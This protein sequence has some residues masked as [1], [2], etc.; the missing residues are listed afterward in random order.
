MLNTFLYDPLVE[1]KKESRSK[2]GTGE[3]SND[4]VSSLVDL[5]QIT[6]MIAFLSLPNFR[7]FA[8]NFI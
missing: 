3:K 7:R 6:A 4:M 1:W 8:I 5:E 2:M